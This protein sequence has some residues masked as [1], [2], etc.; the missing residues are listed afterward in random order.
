MTQLTLNFDKSRFRI[1]E[2]FS[3]AGG[4]TLA[5]H[6]AKYKH[7][8]FDH[9]WANDLDA[10]ACRTL[11]SNIPI[12][13]KVICGDV[14]RLDISDLCPIDG[15]AFGFPCNDFSVI[16]GRHGIAGQYGGLYIW[17]VK[18]L[19]IKQ[20]LFFVAENVGGV[21]SSGG[22][23]DFFVILSALRG[24]GYNIF[25]HTYRFEEYGV[26]QAR[27]RMVIVGFRKDL[28]IDDFEPPQPTHK[29]NFVTAEQA[30]R[31]IPEN[32]PNNER[33]NQSATVVERLKHIKP[34]QNAFNAD[35]PAHLKLRVM[36]GAK[37]SLIYRRL[38][39]DAPSYTVTGSGGGG[40]QC[41]PLGGKQGV[42]QPRAG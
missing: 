32:A 31:N 9:V 28:G 15:L 24:A 33:T 19:E 18:T 38:K 17:G 36:S 30:L 7:Y 42:D 40:T 35:I 21:K 1:G 29:Q 11:E 13:N 2:L 41:V 14:D 8:G 22:K 10:D 37:I 6:T 20:P 26:P 3:G 5:A 16:G 23:R 39:P 12:F 25:P 34:G 4:M 27:H